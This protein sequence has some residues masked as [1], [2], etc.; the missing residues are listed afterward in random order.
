MNNDNSSTSAPISLE[1]LPQ[2]NDADLVILLGCNFSDLKQL[3]SMERFEGHQLSKLKQ[4]WE[5]NAIAQSLDA[6]QAGRVYFIPTYLC[7]GLPGPIG[8]ELYLNE[9]K[10]N[11][12]AIAASG[13]K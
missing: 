8:A 4:A 12:Q 2:L 7:A 3:D 11:V 10:Q 9:L 6:S 13:M 5:K 1:T